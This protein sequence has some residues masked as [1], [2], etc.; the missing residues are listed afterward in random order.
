MGW[1][2]CIISPGSENASRAQGTPAADMDS[3]TP[4]LHIQNLI[5]YGTNNGRGNLLGILI[6]ADS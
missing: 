4:H 3:T 1:E 5:A 6:C 2:Q